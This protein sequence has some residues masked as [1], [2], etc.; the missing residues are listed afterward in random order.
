[1]GAITTRLRGLTDRLTR[2]RTGKRD[3]A[4][5]RAQKRNEAKAQRLSHERL[6]NKLPP[7]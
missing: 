1:M 5:E 3:D 6:D 7:R 2:R 4:G